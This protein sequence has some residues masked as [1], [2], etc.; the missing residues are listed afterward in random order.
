M[1]R[2]AWLCAGGMFGS[3]EKEND[4]R[5]TQIIKHDSGFFVMI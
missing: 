4:G 5:R 3:V 1:A 2:L